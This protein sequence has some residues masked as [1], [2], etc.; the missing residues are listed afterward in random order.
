MHL[1]RKCSSRTD[2]NPKGT[3]K[4][5]RLPPVFAPAAGGFSCAGA[6]SSTP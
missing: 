3:L 6:V 2:A 5:K 4:Q 1:N